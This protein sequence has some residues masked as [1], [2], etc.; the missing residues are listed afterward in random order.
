MDSLAKS[1]S[2]LPTTEHMC[3]PVHA[4]DASEIRAIFAEYSMNHVVRHSFFS[5]LA[6]SLFAASL[7]SAQA[8]ASFDSPSDPQSG[9]RATVEEVKSQTGQ[10]AGAQAQ[11]G[12]QQNSTF[13]QRFLAHTHD[14]GQIQPQST[15]PFVIPDPRLVQYA[16]FAVSHQYTTTGTE[17]VNYGS[18][19]GGGIILYHR[20][21]LDFA[22]PS[23]IVHNSTVK[24]GSGDAT[25]LVKWRVAS[26]GPAHHNYVVTADLAKSWTTG[27]YSNGSRTGIFTPIVATSKGFGN[28]FYVLSSIAGTLP[29]G[30]IAKQGRTIL[31][32]EGVQYHPARWFWLDMENNATFYK[33]GSNDGKTQNFITPGFFYVL[34]PKSWSPTHPFFAFGEGM[35]IATSSFHSY[36]HNLISDFRFVF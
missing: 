9:S 33:G 28:K 36:N 11:T 18:A 26:S 19:H 13:L 17:T 7:L 8:R 23:Y 27:S 25:L 29:T 15:T 31:W 12:Q 4:D 5:S 30:K 1:A 22:P 20:F 34:K 2:P 3:R 6:L 32:N 21:Q 14:M 10:Q 24:D 16:R 35:Q